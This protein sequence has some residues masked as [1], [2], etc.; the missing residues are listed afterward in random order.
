VGVTS[1]RDCLHFNV[2]WKLRKEWKQELWNL[3]RKL[4]EIMDK[5]DDPEKKLLDAVYRILA[6]DCENG[7]IKEGEG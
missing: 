6:Y 3:S 1:C 2:C 5:K 7:K 4:K